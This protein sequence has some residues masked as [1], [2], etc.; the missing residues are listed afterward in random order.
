MRV[1]TAMFFIAILVAP[2]QAADAQCRGLAAISG[3]SKAQLKSE[4]E[5]L[6]EEAKTGGQAC[7]SFWTVIGKVIGR[8]TTAGRRLEKDRPFNQAAAQA[9]VDAAL[10]NPD[11]RKRIEA[12]RSEVPDETVRLMF[13]AIVFDEE[14]YYD[15]RELRIRQLRQGLN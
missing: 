9:N 2:G 1:V 10:R 4:Q 5:S 12:L 11:V 8:E 6:E 15:A 7:A 14:G 3:I 13:E